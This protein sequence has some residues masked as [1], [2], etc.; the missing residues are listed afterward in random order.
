M[1]N[2]FEPAVSTDLIS[3]INKLSPQT[4]PLWGKMSVAQMLA[5]C[6]VT[7]E[8]VYEEKHPKPNA[9]VKFMLK[10]FVKNTVVN[11]KPFKQNGQ[12]AP[13]FLIK[14]EK[15]FEA[16]KDRLVNYIQ[17]TQQLGKTHFEGK[18]SH[19]FGVLNS[20][21]WNNMFYKHLEHHLTQFGV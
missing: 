8:M 12:T 4:Q 3:R 11:E 16:E 9:L 2:V 18:E 7:Y 17:K 1:K 6:N 14:D 19:S 5:H 15:N 21:E 13:A 20:Q 10:L